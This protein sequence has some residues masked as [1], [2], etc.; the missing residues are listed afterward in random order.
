[1]L[2][3]RCNFTQRETVAASPTNDRECKAITNVTM[4]LDMDY[5]INA[6]TT[7]LQQLLVIKVLDSLKN[8]TSHRVVNIILRVLFKKGSVLVLLQILA[9]ETT[10]STELR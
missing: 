3:L 4:Y 1:M 6:G 9:N 10:V 2:S 7:A 8:A 5:D